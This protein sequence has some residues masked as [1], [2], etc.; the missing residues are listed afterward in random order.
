MRN[1][2]RWLFKVIAPY[3]LIKPD[4]LLVS[5]PY[6]KECFRSAFDVDDSIF[7]ELFPPRLNELMSQISNSNDG[8]ST[9]LYAPTWRDDH[10]FSI[11]E[12]I[13]IDTLD[14]FLGAN[15]LHM[16]C[17]PH[18]SD[19]SDY[20]RL[21]QAENITLS[22]KDDDIYIL[23]ARSDILITDYSSMLFEAL[24]LNKEV[25]LFCPDYESY[26][27]NSRTFYRDPCVEMGLASVED[28]ES[29]IKT[30]SATLQNNSS[31]ALS[32]SMK[33]YSISSNPIEEIYKKINSNV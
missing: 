26:Q 20:G 18:P 22:S 15:R 27:S 3:Q 24:Y 6:E 31:S 23:L 1:K 4:I 13:D 33:P 5:S 28:T 8:C 2:Y 21:I 11:E 32:K 16:Y 25:I 12:A 10:S 7:L 29:L 14:K 9:L 19:K 17:K 30:I